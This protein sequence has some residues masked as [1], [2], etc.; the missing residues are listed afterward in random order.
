M[1]DELT[2]AQ[3]EV[4]AM[5]PGTP[6][7]APAEIPGCIEVPADQTQL[8]G[9][10]VGYRWRDDERPNLR[11]SAAGLLLKSAL[12][13]V[14]LFWGAWIIVSTNAR[15]A[16]RAALDIATQAEIA[17]HHREVDAEIAASRAES[18]Q[19]RIDELREEVAIL[20]AR[21]RMIEKPRGRR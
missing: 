6:R 2:E 3:R 14:V 13:G 11:G 21:Q 1:T 18:L 15:I 5:L 7:I 19:A 10:G 12:I 8:L 16:D 4:D 9:L 20:A 17:H